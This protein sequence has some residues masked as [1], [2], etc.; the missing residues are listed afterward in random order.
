MTTRLEHLERLEKHGSLPGDAEHLE[1]LERIP[2]LGGFFHSKRFG[3]AGDREITSTTAR[4]VQNAAVGDPA[5]STRQGTWVDLGG[6][7]SS[8]T[9]RLGIGRTDR[10]AEG[11]KA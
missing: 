7:M 11:M 1:R 6:N 10:S 3:P 8:T 9:L 2:P 4:C 5:A